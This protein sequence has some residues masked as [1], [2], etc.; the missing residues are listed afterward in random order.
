MRRYDSLRG[1]IGVYTSAFYAVQLKK[2]QQQNH[3]TEN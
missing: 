1:Q 3:F 2:Y